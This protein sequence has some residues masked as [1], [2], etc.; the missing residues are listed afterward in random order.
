MF[1]VSVYVDELRVWKPGHRPTCHLTADTPAELR[2]FVKRAGVPAH[3]RHPRARV[4][5]YDLPEMWRRVAL[6][7]GAIEVSAR[8]QAE[9]RIAQKAKL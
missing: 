3:F 1:A 5:H 9:R 6:E 4:P 8:Q 7:H 2:A